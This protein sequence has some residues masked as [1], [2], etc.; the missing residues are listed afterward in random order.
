[1]YICEMQNKMEYKNMKN[2]VTL[3]YYELILPRLF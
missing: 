1:M 2:E 3:D